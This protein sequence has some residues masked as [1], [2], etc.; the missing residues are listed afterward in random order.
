[1]LGNDSARDFWLPLVL[2]AIVLYSTLVALKTGSTTFFHRKL[3]RN[4][5]GFM[6]WL[7]VLLPLVSA[8]AL[9]ILMAFPG[10]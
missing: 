10:R 8:L 6:F 9:L 4:D 2:S 5:D 3:T 7:G 1:M